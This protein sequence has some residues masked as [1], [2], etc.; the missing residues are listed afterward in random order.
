MHKTQVETKTDKSFHHREHREDREDRENRENR[1]NKI[2]LGL[3][4]KP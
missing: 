1:E 3:N 2:A 4:Q